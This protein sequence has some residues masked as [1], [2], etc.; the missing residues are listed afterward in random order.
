MKDIVE[1]GIVGYRGNSA[2][3]GNRGNRME[4]GIIYGGRLSGQWNVSP[5]RNRDSD[6]LFCTGNR[7]GSGEPP[8]PLNS[9]FKNILTLTSGAQACPF[10]PKGLG[11]KPAVGK[12]KGA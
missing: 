11:S 6:F 10:R 9:R 5:T 12:P 1:G 4:R 8:L 7:I 3:K 2:E